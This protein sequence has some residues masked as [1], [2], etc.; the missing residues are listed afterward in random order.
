MTATISKR[1]FLKFAMGSGLALGSCASAVARVATDDMKWDKTTDVLV[2]GFGGAGAA[3]AI[4]AKKKGADVLILEKMPQPGGNTAVSAGGFMC[5]DDEAKAYEYL[6]G[7]YTYSHAEMDEA[8][9]RTFCREVMDLKNFVTGL[10]D[11]VKL[12]VYGYA[13]FKNLPCQEVIKRYR[14]RGRKGG[15]KKGAG[16]CLFDLLKS[17]ELPASESRV[18]LAL[19]TDLAAPDLPLRKSL[20]DSIVETA[21]S[22]LSQPDKLPLIAQLLQLAHALYALHTEPWMLQHFVVLF[23][24]FANAAA[25]TA[26][27]AAFVLSAFVELAPKLKI[28]HLRFFIATCAVEVIGM[29]V[30]RV[31]EFGKKE[32]SALV[33]FAALCYGKTE[34]KNEVVDLVIRL[35]ALALDRSVA[36][37]PM[38]VSKAV[39]DPEITKINGMIGEILFVVATANADRM[40]ITIQQLPAASATNLQNQLRKTVQV[41]QMESSA[42]RRRNANR[43][44]VKLDASKFTQ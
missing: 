38:D 15:P 25:A 37:Q 30:P 19:L 43:M 27:R 9:L 3:A 21:L 1:N 6:K 28:D 44:P 33:Q 26:E 5:P 42:A 31:N 8:L 14:V 10:A 17:H 2:L 11:N 40:K 32:L 34:K 13:G 36:L 24:A 4:E 41:K 18:L 29:V 22:L 20:L 12:F 39:E 16:D 35:N 23:H 7:T